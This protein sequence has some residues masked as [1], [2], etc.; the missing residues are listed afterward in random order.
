MESLVG[1]PDVCVGRPKHFEA[2]TEAVFRWA[3]ETSSRVPLSDFYWTT[4]GQQ[5]VLHE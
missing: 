2:I 1:C 4:T 3:N 5:A